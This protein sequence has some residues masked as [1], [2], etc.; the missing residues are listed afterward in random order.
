MYAV[1]TLRS[2]GAKVSRVISIADWERG[3][4]ENLKK[5]GIEMFSVFKASEVL[6]L[7]PDQYK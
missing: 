5:E 6:K 7:L 2:R 1:N 3:G 4:P